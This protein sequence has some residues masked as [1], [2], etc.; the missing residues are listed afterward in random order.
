MGTGIG[1]GNREVKGNRGNREI[2]E[3]IQGRVSNP[4]FGIVLKVNFLPPI[5]GEMFGMRKS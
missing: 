5:N 2:K 4:H 3:N 1:K